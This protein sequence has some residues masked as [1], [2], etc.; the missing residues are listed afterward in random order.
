MSGAKKL[1]AHPA[2]RI[3]HGISFSVRDA[4]ELLFL[5]FE[6]FGQYFG[7]GGR[8][9]RAFPA[10]TGGVIFPI[11]I[12]HGKSSVLEW[13]NSPYY[14]GRHHFDYRIPGLGKRPDLAQELANFRTIFLLG[15]PGAPAVVL[16]QRNTRKL[17]ET[18]PDWIRKYDIINVNHSEV[19]SSD[20]F[21]GVPDR[22]PVSAMRHTSAPLTSNID[23]SWLRGTRQNNFL[24]S[25]KWASIPRNSSHK[26]T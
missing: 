19:H 21:F 2:R 25:S 24:H 15:A 12:P 7:Y 26:A 4:Q 5:T 18:S 13:L 20:A 10:A 1:G 3:V 6:Q 22:Y 17:G 11:V 9:V 14:G 23:P 16:L 8:G